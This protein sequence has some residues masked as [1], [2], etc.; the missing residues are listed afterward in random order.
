MDTKSQIT[1]DIVNIGGNTAH[2]IERNITFAK[3][4]PLPNTPPYSS[5]YPD[6]SRSISLERGR[7][8][9]ECLPVDDEII[10]NHIRGLRM[11]GKVD[12]SDCYLFG[13]IDYYD[14]FNFS[15]RSAFCRRYNVKTRR[16]TKVEDEH[17]EYN[18]Y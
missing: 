5:N 3:L 8:S 12:E 15:G 18:S 16:F 11:M 7:G 4:N 2:V 1:F 9:G 6:L 13:Y 10:M 14:D 17:Y